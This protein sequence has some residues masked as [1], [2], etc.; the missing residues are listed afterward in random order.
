MENK[1][2]SRNQWIDALGI[3]EGRR[4]SE[5]PWSAQSKWSEHPEMRDKVPSRVSHMHRNSVE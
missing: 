2:S 4:Q 5:C 1:G 3:I